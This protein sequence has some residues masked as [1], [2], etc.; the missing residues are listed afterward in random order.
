MTSISKRKNVLEF[1]NTMWYNISKGKGFFDPKCIIFGY[2]VLV[3]TSQIYAPYTF[4]AVNDKSQ[5]SAKKQ[6]KTTILAKNRRFSPIFRPQKASWGG[7]GRRF[8]SCHSDQE[9][10]EMHK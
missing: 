6:E 1:L 8:K 3:H 2:I 5:Q 4:C 10:D 7:R 9:I